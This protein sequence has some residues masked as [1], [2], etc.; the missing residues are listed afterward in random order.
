[1]CFNYIGI[2]RLCIEGAHFCTERKSNQQFLIRK[3]FSSDFAV[4]AYLTEVVWGLCG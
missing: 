2:A 4:T 3:I 1:M